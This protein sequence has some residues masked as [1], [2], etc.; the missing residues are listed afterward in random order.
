M[1][2]G[3][4]ARAR[5][6]RR[7]R[8]GATDLGRAGGA[9]LEVRFVAGRRV[10]KA[11]RRGR[12][13]SLADVNREVCA[14]IGPALYRSSATR[15][16][17]RPDPELGFVGS[18]APRP[19]RSRRAAAGLIPVVAPLGVGPLSVTPTRRP[20]RSP[21][22][23]APS[24]SSSSPTCGP[25]ARRRRATTIRVL[26]PSA[27]STRASSRAGS[28][29]SCAPRSARRGAALPPRSA[30][31][32]WS[33]EL[34][35]RLPRCSPRM[36]ATT[37]PSSPARASG[38]PTRGGGTSTC[39]PA[40][41]SSRSATAIPAPL[42]A[43]QHAAQ[44]A[45]ARLEPLLDRADAAA[46]RSARPLRRAR[47]RSSATPAPRR[48]RPRAQVGAEGNGK[49][50]RRARETLPR[51]HGALARPASRRSGPRGSRSRRRCGSPT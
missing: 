5:C 15:S 11:E 9:G 35:A 40:S 13:R 18:P 23:S 50:G 45:L 20:P 24:G 1:V 22:G 28:C 34:A 12:A 38:S 37:S 33:R 8:R 27:C 21:S 49:R 16:A 30:L 32:R 42:A 14:A 29:R 41:P 47:G 36:R 43:A 48:S 4:A 19:P 39:S 10:T 3:L 44:R 2:L 26:R 51:T 6:L 17:S 31:R 25:P 7:P 46:R